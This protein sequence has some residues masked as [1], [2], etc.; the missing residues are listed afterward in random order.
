MSHHTESCNSAY[1]D[2]LVDVHLTSS[3]YDVNAFK[4]G[5]CTLR[6]IE[7]EELGDVMRC[8]LL[9]LQCH[10]GLDTL[11]WARLGAQVT[12]VD[13]SPRAVAA[14]Q[15]LAQEMGIDA[16]FVTSEVGRL[17]EKLNKQ[18]DI[19]YTSYGVLV[20]LS[21]L[22]AWADTVIHCLKPGGIFYIIDEHPSAAVFSRIVDG[23]GIYPEFP[24]ENSGHP[25][26]TRK[27]YPVSESGTHRAES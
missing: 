10:I 14:A 5:A 16:R 24:Y 18:F 7:R 11:S 17:K 20:W 21:C 15:E 23:G 26:I 22:R 25:Y 1:W 4:E 3:Y 2:E 8:S 9:H 27:V 19:V 12:G 13:F 6:S